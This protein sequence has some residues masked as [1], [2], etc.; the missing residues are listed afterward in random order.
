MLPKAL[1][2]WD[3]REQ[4]KASQEEVGTL[5]SKLDAAQTEMVKIVVQIKGSQDQ[6]ARLVEQRQRCK[7]SV[8]TSL[9]ATGATNKPPR[10]NLRCSSQ[11]LERRIQDRRRPDSSCLSRHEF[12]F[13]L[14]A[15]NCGCARG[16]CRFQVQPN[17]CLAKP[18]QE[19]CTQAPVTDRDQVNFIHTEYVGRPRR[20][21]LTD[22]SGD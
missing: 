2:R 15:S 18:V 4:L 21:R 11:N 12:E 20:N 1:W 5:A 17:D 14:L 10:L 8:A 7:P 22:H 19:T 16:E 13:A 9:P 3:G 6:I